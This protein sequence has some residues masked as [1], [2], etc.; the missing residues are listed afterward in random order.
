MDMVVASRGGSGEGRRRR[1]VRAWIAVLGALGMVPL[2]GCDLPT[3]ALLLLDAGS[4][5]IQGFRLW[6]L[7]DDGSY[8]EAYR[9]ELDAPIADRDVVNYAVVMDEKTL[10]W[11][12]PAA[13]ERQPDQPEVAT[14]QPVLLPGIGAGEYRLSAY[15]AA[16][17]S[18]L[19]SEVITR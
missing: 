5:T 1:G 14:L 15:N 7:Q 19:S 9:I 6:K 12:I 10:F 4:N 8:T 3:V 2:G 16:G 11:G 18:A 17:D 13:V